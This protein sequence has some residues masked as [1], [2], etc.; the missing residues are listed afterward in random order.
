MSETYEPSD[1]IYALF[2]L[3]V[4]DYQLSITDWAIMK[5]DPDF[6][7][8]GMWAD[9]S[10]LYPSWC[11]AVVGAGDFMWDYIDDKYTVAP[12]EEG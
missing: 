12:T 6:K 4:I 10:V 7:K 8:V 5:S 1:D 3:D 11:K 9:P 2:I